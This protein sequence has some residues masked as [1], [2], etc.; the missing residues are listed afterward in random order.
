MI[1]AVSPEFIKEAGLAVHPLPTQ[2]IQGYLA[3]KK[4]SPRRTPPQA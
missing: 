1:A 3:H 2:A 4:P